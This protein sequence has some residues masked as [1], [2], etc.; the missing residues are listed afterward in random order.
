MIAFLLSIA[1]ITRA[2]QVQSKAFDQLLKSMLKQD[3]PLITVSELAKMPQKPLLLDA[4]ERHEYA[5]SHIPGAQWIGY[6]TFNLT[7]LK[8]IPKNTPLVVYCSI[9]VRSEKIGRELKAAGF[10]QVQNLY[11]SIFEWVNQGHPVES[12]PGKPTQRVHAYNRMW[13]VWLQK[14]KKVYE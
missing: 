14:G 2:Q 8:N 13:G 1:G 3:V 7:S 11:G 10:T 5:V 6:E 12:A 4:R 9:G